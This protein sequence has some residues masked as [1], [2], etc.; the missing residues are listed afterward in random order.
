[1]QNV[2]Q[3][4]QLVQSSFQRGQAASFV[5]PQ[6]V[7]PP[8]PPLP[9]KPKAVSSSPSMWHGRHLACVG[10]LQQ[11]VHKSA[12]YH[13]AAPLESYALSWWSV[14]P[15]SAICAPMED[16]KSAHTSVRH[17]MRRANFYIT[18]GCRITLLLFASI[19]SRRQTAL[20]TW[21]CPHCL[22]ESRKLQ[23]LLVSACGPA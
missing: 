15:V 10:Q 18:G 9:P 22:T 12:K 23:F 14:L 21:R 16:E 19:V 2:K 13:A 3:V 6:N 5:A 4:Q 1:M 17:K 7:A 11:L 20:M 8:L